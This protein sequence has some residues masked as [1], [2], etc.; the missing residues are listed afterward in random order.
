MAN[1]G[2]AVHGGRL[3][4]ATLDAHVMALDLKTGKPVW[5]VPLI[6]YR[7]ATPPPPRRSW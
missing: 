7:R 1:R 6:D 2:F 4:M 5:D 3:F